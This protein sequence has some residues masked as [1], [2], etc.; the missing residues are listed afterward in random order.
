MCSLTACCGSCRPI[1]LASR[2][3]GTEPE[4]IRAIVLAAQS[5]FAVWTV[6]KRS[7]PPPAR[8][9]ARSAGPS[10]SLLRGRARLMQGG[11]EQV[12][13][14]SPRMLGFQTVIFTGSPGYALDPSAQD[15]VAP[16][17]MDRAHTRGNPEK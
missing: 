14:R 2:P 5:M 16:V 8:R 1:A 3:A 13:G 6:H 17:Q 12:G 11:G 7:R 9:S 4:V 10:H 15:L